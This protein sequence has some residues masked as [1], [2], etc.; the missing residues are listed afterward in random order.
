MDSAP[1]IEGVLLT[2][3]FIVWYRHNF[4]P[5]S[6]Y[7]W[8][9]QT[10]FKVWMILPSTCPPTKT[11]LQGKLSEVGRSFNQTC[12]WMCLWCLI[13]NMSALVC[14]EGCQAISNCRILYIIVLFG[15]WLYG[16]NDVFASPTCSMVLE[17]QHLPQKT[18][19][20][21]MD[22]M[23]HSRPGRLFRALKRGYGGPPRTMA[24]RPRVRAQEGFWESWPLG[25]L[26]DV[27]C[28][29]VPGKNVVK[30][31]QNLVKPGWDLN[32]WFVSPSVTVRTWI[33]ILSF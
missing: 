3:S 22:A 2:A 17:C 4:N 14:L 31:L 13:G 12:C 7:P 33:G 29:W 32:R 25:D 9:V 6:M 8:V 19:P 16:L 21:T 18:W 24:A 10:D 11:F 26:R 30:I 1:F 20:S 27:V 28:S 15:W 23:E 5:G